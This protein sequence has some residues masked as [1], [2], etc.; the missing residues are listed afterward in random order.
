MA[1]ELIKTDPKILNI[2]VFVIET[3]NLHFEE[4]LKISKR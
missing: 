3:E 1:E 4:Q 2:V